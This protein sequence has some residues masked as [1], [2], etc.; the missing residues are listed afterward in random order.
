MRFGALD[1]RKSCFGFSACLIVKTERVLATL[2]HVFVTLHRWSSF[3]PMQ[4]E[5]SSKSYC[6]RAEETTQKNLKRPM[7]AGYQQLASQLNASFPFA[8]ADT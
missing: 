7:W 1:C 2:V 6:T 4:L 3:L 5:H 8:D